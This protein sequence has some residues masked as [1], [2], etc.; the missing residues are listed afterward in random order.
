MHYTNYIRRNW[1]LSLK[2]IFHDLRTKKDPSEFR[3][4]GSQIYHGYQ[5][6]GKTASMVH[7]MMLLKKRYPRL[8][9]CSNL[10]LTT[11]SPIVVNTFEELQEAISLIDP[12]TQYLKFETFEQA[13][14]LLRYARNSSR[15]VL[16]LIDEIHNYFHSHDSKAI[17]LWV[18]QVFSQQRKQYVLVIGT[19]QKWPDLTKVIRD[20]IDNLILCRR[21]GYFVSNVA[22][23][24]REMAN[25]FGELVAPIRKKG[26][27]FLTRQIRES[28]DTYQVID[29]GRQVLGGQ[30]MQVNVKSENEQKK[31]IFGRRATR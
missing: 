3:P 29:S 15:G 23:D 9:I 14:I 26:F 28:Y 5:G 11:Y 16:F 6:E 21:F 2:T 27:Y 22:I 4:N 31:K 8:L 10:V 20:Q 17:P 13:M 19:V 25:E 18:V 24:P 12:R 30:E 7:A 1:K